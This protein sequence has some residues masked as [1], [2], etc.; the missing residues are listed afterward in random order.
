MAWISNTSSGPP[1][2][3]DAADIH[4]EPRPSSPWMVIGRYVLSG[5]RLNAIAGMAVR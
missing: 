2:D 3:G 4:G 5:G 1:G